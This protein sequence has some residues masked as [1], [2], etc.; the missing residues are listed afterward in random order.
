M[1][2][3]KINE[4]WAEALM[5]V[6]IAVHLNPDFVISGDFRSIPMAVSLRNHKI[7]WKTKEISHSAAA[8][9]KILLAFTSSNVPAKSIIKEIK[10]SM[11]CHNKCML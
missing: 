6:E 1:F 3:Y 8:K 9:G 11:K 10:L 4:K 2:K 5:D 7:I